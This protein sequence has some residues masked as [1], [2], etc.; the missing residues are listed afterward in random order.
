M[1]NYRDCFNSPKCPSQKDFSESRGWLSPGK[2]N[3]FVSSEGRI[4]FHRLCEVCYKSKER[5]FS[6]RNKQLHKEL[7]ETKAERDKFQSLY[8]TMFDIAQK[9]KKNFQLRRGRNESRRKPLTSREFLHKMSR[10]D[11]ESLPPKKRQK[12]NGEAFDF[13]KTFDWNKTH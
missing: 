2:P 10:S 5:S 13:L 8:Y 12:S 4:I 3:Y 1:A 9:S 6:L 7:E 11:D